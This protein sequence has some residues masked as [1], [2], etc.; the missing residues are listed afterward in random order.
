[1]REPDAGRYVHVTPRH[2]PPKCLDCIDAL[3]D[4]HG[5]NRDLAR[6]MAADLHQYDEA[7]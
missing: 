4:E 2:L 1:M 3:A 5:I 7:A 6:R